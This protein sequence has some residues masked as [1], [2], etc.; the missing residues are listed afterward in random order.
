MRK[1][2]IA[3]LYPALFFLD[4]GESFFVVILVVKVFLF[5]CILLGIYFFYIDLCSVRE[6]SFIVAEMT[7][8]DTFSGRIGLQ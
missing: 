6:N 8:A 4:R 2:K 3:H 1:R 7:A 5:F